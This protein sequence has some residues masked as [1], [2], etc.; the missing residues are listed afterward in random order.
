MLKDSDLRNWVHGK[1]LAQKDVLLLAMA[2]SGFSPKSTADLKMLLADAGG[3]K[4]ARKWNVAAILAKVPEL[5]IQS[6]ACWEITEK[7]R[8]HVV[9]LGIVPETGPAKIITDKLSIAASAI[10]ST[11]TRVFV[12][13]AIECFR[14]HFYRAAVVLSWVGAVSAMY[15]YVVANKLIEFNTAASLAP[16]DTHIPKPFLFT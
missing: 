5:A 14:A 15:D 11:D 3:L 7:G 8:A 9:A 2:V 16:G 13:E 1:S 6:K 10:S 12:E 4:K